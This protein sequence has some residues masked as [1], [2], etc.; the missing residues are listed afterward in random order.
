ME[1]QQQID[2]TYPAQ[3]Y[4]KSF[5]HQY[6][7]DQRQIKLHIFQCGGKIEQTLITGV[8]RKTTLFV[9]FVIPFHEYTIL[10]QSLNRFIYP[11]I[12][13]IH[14]SGAILKTGLFTHPSITFNPI[15]NNKVIEKYLI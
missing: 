8:K 12:S 14:Y 4:A 7:T 2:L 15:Y 5:F 11:S 1:S 3:E 13:R 9:S 6:P 10:E